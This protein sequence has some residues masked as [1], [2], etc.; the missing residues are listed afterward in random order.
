MGC[1]SLIVFV[2]VFMGSLALPLKDPLRT[3]ATFYD[4]D[5]LGCG[6]LGV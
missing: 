2:S 6:A 4:N 5:D 1:P 3:S